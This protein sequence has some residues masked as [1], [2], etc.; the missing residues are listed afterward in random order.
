[1]HRNAQFAGQI[2]GIPATCDG[3][4]FLLRAGSRWIAT[5]SQH[6]IGD[7]GQLGKFSNARGEKRPAFGS[8]IRM[9]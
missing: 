6:F 3:P 2:S 7:E 8:R 9:D 1:V 5:G 4:L